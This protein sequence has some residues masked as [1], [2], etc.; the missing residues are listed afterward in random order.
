ML[1]FCCT[2]CLL[3]LQIYPPADVWKSAVSRAPVQLWG[4]L[5]HSAS[6]CALSQAYSRACPAPWTPTSEQAH[7]EPMISGSESSITAEYRHSDLSINKC[8]MIIAKFLA[9]FI[10]AY[11]SAIGIGSLKQ[12]AGGTLLFVVLP[13]NFKGCF[14]TITWV[15]VIGIETDL[16]LILFFT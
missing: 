6:L 16:L 3:T 11:K 8:Y 4:G 15:T 2:I 5:W 12:N 7:E 13:W 10:T 1:N 9:D 14:C